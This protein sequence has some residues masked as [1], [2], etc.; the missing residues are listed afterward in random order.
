[1]VCLR[2]A[3]EVLAP[4]PTEHERTKGSAIVVVIG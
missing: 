2:L 3:N 4:P 1:V